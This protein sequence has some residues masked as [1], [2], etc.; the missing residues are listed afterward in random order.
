MRSKMSF[1]TFYLLLFAY[2]CNV[3]MSSPNQ[4]T[5]TSLRLTEGSYWKVRSRSL[6]VV[7]TL[8]DHNRHLSIY[9]IIDGDMTSILHF[10]FLQSSSLSNNSKASIELYH[11]GN[12][13]HTRKVFLRHIPNDVYLSIHNRR[14]V[15]CKMQRE[16]KMQFE[17]NV[18]VCHTNPWIYLDQFDS[19]DFCDQNGA[20]VIRFMSSSLR[21]KVYYLEVTKRSWTMNI[22]SQLWVIRHGLA[23]LSQRICKRVIN[24]L[25]SPVIKKRKKK[26]R[27]S[28][29]NRRKKRRRNRGA[30]K[31]DFCQKRRNEIF[32]ELAGVTNVTERLNVILKS[33][34]PCGFA[35]Y[36]AA[37][38]IANVPWLERTQTE[39]NILICVLS[40]FV[41]R[42]LRDVLFSFDDTSCILKWGNLNELKRRTLLDDYLT[43]NLIHFRGGITS[44]TIARHV[45]DSFQ[46]RVASLCV[47]E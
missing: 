29:R 22:R 31:T 17:A 34:N 1:A 47:Y 36:T 32:Q 15:A 24:F 39:E 25:L 2:N 14:V 8:K 23:T 12:T 38:V 26:K 20:Y 37:D 7:I 41:K 42:L 11:H 6:R 5:T 40:H 45:T 43:A 16:K 30:Q 9:P 4:N 18:D 21:Y 33:R 3:T 44:S 35:N 10:G 28:E 46:H 19:S 27:R 13:N